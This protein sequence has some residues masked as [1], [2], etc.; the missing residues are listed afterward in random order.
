MDGLWLQAVPKI[1]GVYLS[2][3][4]KLCFNTLNLIWTRCSVGEVWLADWES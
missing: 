4:R 3:Q 2:V 1:L